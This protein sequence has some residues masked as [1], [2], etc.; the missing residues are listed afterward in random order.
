MVLFTALGLALVIAMAAGQFRV[1]Y[2]AINHG[3]AGLGK[4]TYSRSERPF[5]FWTVLVIE[6]LGFALIFAYL[7]ALM[8]A[9]LLP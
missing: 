8:S 7:L 9:L 3:K 4:F 5:A 1:A 2:R 6:W